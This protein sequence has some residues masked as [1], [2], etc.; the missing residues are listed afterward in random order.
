MPMYR[1]KA[2]NRNGDFRKGNLESANEY[3]L[4]QRLHRLGLD[5][6]NAHTVRAKMGVSNSRPVERIDLIN[7]CFHMEQL[8]RSGV[9]LLDGLADLR[10]S[11]EHPK[12][13]MVVAS[14]FDE[15]EAGSSLSNA[16]THHDEVFDTLFVS[17]IKAGEASG[18]LPDVLESLSETLKWQDE[19]NRSTRKLVMAPAIV[20]TVVMGV[21]TFLMTY[22]VPQLVGFLTTMGQELPIHTRALIAT[23]DFFSSYWYVILLTPVVIFQASKFAIQHSNIVKFQFHRMLLGSFK[24]GPILQKIILSRFANFFAMMYSAGIP[25]L[26]GIMLI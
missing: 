24:I 14:L 10:D 17:L 4:E 5:L 7:F 15:I 19:L 20:M 16:M 22:L 9:P 2:M 25:I 11:L 12:F 6:I 8:T 26:E 18:Q 1:Y 23:S 21:T 13:R 3:D